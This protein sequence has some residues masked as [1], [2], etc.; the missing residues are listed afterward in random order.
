MVRLKE[1]DK[2]QFILLNKST[3]FQCDY[4]NSQNLKIIKNYVQPAVV[5]NQFKLLIY[6]CNCDVSSS[7][8]TKN[9]SEIKEKYISNKNYL[10]LNKRSFSSDFF[11]FE[12]DFDTHILP[13][14][15]HSLLLTYLPSPLAFLLPNHQP[16]LL[17][18]A[19][20]SECSFND[21]YSP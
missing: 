4:L 16:A 7:I 15:H 14:C 6:W 17:T 1:M 5:Y 9:L 18:I 2:K 10:N 11:I 13:T 12:A 19:K 8:W 3:V 20:T 21:S